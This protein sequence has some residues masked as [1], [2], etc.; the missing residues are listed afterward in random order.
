MRCYSLPLIV[1][2]LFVDNR[3]EFHYMCGSRHVYV[4]IVTA[5]YFQSNSSTQKC[6]AQGYSEAQK[7]FIGYL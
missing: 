4:H 7:F 6:T 2:D 5:H 1:I 3:A